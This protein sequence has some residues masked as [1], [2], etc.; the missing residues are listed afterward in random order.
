MRLQSQIELPIQKLLSDKKDK[1][2]NNVAREISGK[3][4]ATKALVKKHHE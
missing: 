1:R 3:N 4:K 2:T